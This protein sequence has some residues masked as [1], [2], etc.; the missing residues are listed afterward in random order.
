MPRRKLPPDRTLELCRRAARFVEAIAASGIE[1]PD[2]LAGFRAATEMTVVRQA[3]QSCLASRVVRAGLDG[4][5]FDLAIRDTLDAHCEDAA[6][7]LEQWGLGWTD[8]V[9]AAPVLVRCLRSMDA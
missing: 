8:F 2:V 6:D 4:P 7:P 9:A 1:I 3:L 5:A